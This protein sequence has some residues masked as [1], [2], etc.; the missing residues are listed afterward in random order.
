MSNTWKR[1]VRGDTTDRA[2]GCWEGG[3]PGGQQQGKGAQ[4]SLLCHMARSLRLHDKGISFWWWSL[5]N[6]LARSISSDSGFFPVGARSA[7]DSSSE[8]FWEVRARHI[9]SSFLLLASPQFFRLAFIGT[10]FF[11][12]IS[13]CKTTQASG[14][15]WLSGWFWLTITGSLMEE[16]HKSRDKGLAT[17]MA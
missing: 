3:V 15:A 7:M 14:Y 2:R 11:T 4:G 16:H 17:R 5:A 6:R 9:L 10:E 12:G 8:G 1:I 13:C